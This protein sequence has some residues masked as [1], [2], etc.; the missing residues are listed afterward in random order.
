MFV[1]TS[2]EAE[3]CVIRISENRC[4]TLFSFNVSGSKRKTLLS[5]TSVS[6]REFSAARLSMW[7][8]SCLR[9][10]TI[11]RVFPLIYL[12]SF[13][14]HSINLLSLEAGQTETKKVSIFSSKKRKNLSRVLTFNIP[15]AN[16][17]LYHFM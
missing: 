13:Q 2:S 9:D 10:E 7:I 6:E 15:S 16:I 8:Q 1:Q 4:R 14:I 3:Y 5:D 17:S 11:S 12:F